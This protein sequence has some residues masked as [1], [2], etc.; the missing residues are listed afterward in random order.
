MAAGRR[1]RML[2]SP[3]DRDRAVTLLQESFVE[4]RLARDEFEQR[5]GQ[6]LV[7]RDFRELLMLTADLPVRSPFDRMPAH[8]ITPRRPADGRRPR[9]WLVRIIARLGWVHAGQPSSRLM[10]GRDRARE[11]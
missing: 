3:A 5:L 10:T 8:R 2:A 6:A 4:G 9:G 7:S 1:A 11:A